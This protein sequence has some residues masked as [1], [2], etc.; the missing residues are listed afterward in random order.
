M[1][2]THRTLAMVLFI[3]IIFS[4]TLIAMEAGEG[5]D[6]EFHVKSGG[7]ELYIKVRGQDIN[8]PVLLYLHGGPGE[9][10]GHLLF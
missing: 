10:N 4:N 1:N 6:K 2:K 9:A 5:I 7:A 8:K 3:A